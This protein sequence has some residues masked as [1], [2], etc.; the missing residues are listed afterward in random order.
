MLFYILSI[1]Y[2]ITFLQAKEV[3]LNSQFLKVFPINLH[4]YF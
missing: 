2:N 4:F 1:I 3:L